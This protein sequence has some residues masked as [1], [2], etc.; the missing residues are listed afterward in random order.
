MIQHNLAVQET[1][2]LIIHFAAIV[3]QH[4]V[5]EM[6][7]QKTKI[8]FAI[9]TFSVA[10]ETNILIIKTVLN[11]IKNYIAVTEIAGEITHLDAHLVIK[12]KNVVE[13]K[14]AKLTQ[15]ALVT[16]IFAVVKVTPGKPTSIANVI[17][18]QSA[19]K[20]THFLRILI[21]RSVTQ[22][23]VAAQTILTIIPDA[24]VIP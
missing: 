2:T 12:I 8:V 19:V 21:A 9:K 20:E 1:L 17:Q 23:R 10:M 13:I 15:I 16:L 5:K 24:S 3:I 4:V 18:T 11:V 14:L 6:F 22:Q 7:I